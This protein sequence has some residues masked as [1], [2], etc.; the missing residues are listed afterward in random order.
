MVENGGHGFYTAE[1]A[2]EIIAEYFGMNLNENEIQE[3]NQA[4]NYTEN[5]R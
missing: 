2:K 3:N 1:V 5:V 4:I